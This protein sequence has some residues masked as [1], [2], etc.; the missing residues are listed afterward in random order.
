MVHPRHPASPQAWLTGSAGTFRR[1]SSQ[2]AAH[3]CATLVG[4]G[5]LPTDREPC[6]SHPSYRTKTHCC[7]SWLPSHAGPGSAE[8]GVTS[9]GPPLPS[10]SAL[11]TLQLI[12]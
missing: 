9:P 3:R 4:S 6:I 7:R 10:A 5:F 12:Y 1:L 8:R 2:F 11:P